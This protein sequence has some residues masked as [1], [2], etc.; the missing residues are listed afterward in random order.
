MYDGDQA[1]KAGTGLDSQSCDK[2]VKTRNN[3]QKRSRKSHGPKKRRRETNE[4]ENNSVYVS[5]EYASSKQKNSNLIKMFYF[6]EV[7]NS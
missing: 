4:I 2:T 3:M 7:F 5:D 6:H 1:I